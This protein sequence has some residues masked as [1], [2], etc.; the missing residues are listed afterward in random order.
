[1]TATGITLII[2]QQLKDFINRC[3]H[4]NNININNPNINQLLVREWFI[5]NS[6]LINRNFTN[7]N[8]LLSIIWQCPKS[9][10]CNACNE[11]N[12]NR[13]CELSRYTLTG[14]YNVS[15][16]PDMFILMILLISDI[17]DINNLNDLLNYKYFNSNKYNNIIMDEC[18]TIEC[19]NCNDNCNKVVKYIRCCCGHLQI[20]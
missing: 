19:G 8:N 15:N 17:D 5:N 4:E 13:R 16:Y 11:C 2:N 9:C 18:G 1:M 10:T 12:N 6:N 3:K 20:F 14:T 7:I